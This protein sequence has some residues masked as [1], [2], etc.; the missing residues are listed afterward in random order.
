MDRLGRWL[1]KKKPERTSRVTR[2]TAS[3]TATR[4]SYNEEIVPLELLDVPPAKAMAFPCGNF[5]AADSIQ[6]EFNTLC[7][8]A[9]LTRP[10]TCRVLQ[11]QKLTV[12][13]INS[14][15]FYTDSDTVVFQIY[16]KL[17]TMPMSSFCDT[18]GFP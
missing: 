3:P 10:A 15:R 18:L 13:F 9:G 4:V 14:F 16:D 12:V 7:A 6:E 2:S 1:G 5:M 8:S 17:L 11:Y